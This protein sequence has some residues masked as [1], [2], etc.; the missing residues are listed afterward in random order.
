MLQPVELQEVSANFPGEIASLR[1]FFSLAGVPLDD[2]SSVHQ[3]VMR[4]L[5]DPSF[6]RDLSSHLWVI[7]DESDVPLRSPDLLAIVAVA[8]AGVRWAAEINEDDAHALLRFL[9]ETK[10]SFDGTPNRGDAMMAGPQARTEPKQPLAM[11][12]HD[13]AVK[14]REPELPLRDGAVQAEPR[15]VLPRREDRRTLE[16]RRVE[17]PN[18]PGRP[19]QVGVLDA[20][21]SRRK[22][23]RALWVVAAA[24]VLAALLALWQR[25]RSTTPGEV[26]VV[27]SANVPKSP[28]GGASA[29]EQATPNA[30]TATA[31]RDRADIASSRSTVP[32]STTLHPPP[33][34][35]GASE[36]NASAAAPTPSPSDVSQPVLSANAGAPIIR[37][38]PPSAS[39]T[40]S[41]AS[42]ASLF[43]GSA[44][45]KTARQPSLTAPVPA[46]ALSRQLDSPRLPAYAADADDNGRRRSPR[47][48]RRHPGEAGNSG[49]SDDPVL[50]AELRAPDLASGAVRPVPGTSV[51]ALVRATCLGMMA[52]NLVYSPSPQYPAGAASARVQ[53]EVKIQATIDRDGS[54]G[55]ARVI[56]GPPPL[57]DAALD[58]VQQWR[59]KP[60]LSAGKATPSAAMAVV[61]FELQ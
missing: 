42:P 59:F 13:P 31:P 26:T 28:T 57:R 51:H 17:S 41:S 20:G 10:H 8:G 58:A 18:Q 5:E 44:V 23:Q 61:E 3:I 15:P 25:S 54:I 45:A 38:S 36:G 37:V 12:A 9:M 19:S 35:Q 49:L 30:T 48:L 4:L 11:P 52:G 6:H 43:P 24:V 29:R 32:S 33:S 34:R 53:G 60:Y 22:D 7:L 16:N 46:D 56:S 14:A 21:V 40:A 1:K 47:L 39:L 50:A 27:P 55:S 2:S